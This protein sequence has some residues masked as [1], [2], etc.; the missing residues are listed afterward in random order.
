MTEQYIQFYSTPNIAP[1]PRDTL[2]VWVCVR[3]QTRQMKR[4]LH[5]LEF[6]EFQRR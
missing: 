6:F 4:R 3:T 5:F 2:V 1:K